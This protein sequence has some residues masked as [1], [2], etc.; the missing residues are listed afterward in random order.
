MLLRPA[1]RASTIADQL[2]TGECR[3]GYLEYG[4]TNPFGYR[5]I[6]GSRRLD[7]HLPVLPGEDHAGWASVGVGSAM[8]V[9]GLAYTLAVRCDEGGTQL[10]DGDEAFNDQIPGLFIM[11]T[12]ISLAL[13]AGL[14]MLVRSRRLSLQT[15]N[16]GEVAFHP[17]PTGMSI[18]GRF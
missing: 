1:N 6:G 8:F 3:F 14:P 18:S 12:G 17:A 11:G 7:D 4:V 13:F 16:G 5:L 2:L 10:C 9:G 15:S